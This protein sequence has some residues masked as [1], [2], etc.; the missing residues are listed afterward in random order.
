MVLR[1]DLEVCYL[2]ADCVE[3]CVG[4]HFDIIFKVVK[5]KHYGCHDMSH[6]HTQYHVGGCLYRSVYDGNNVSWQNFC[7]MNEK[8][9]MCIRMTSYVLFGLFPHEVHKEITDNCFRLV[10]RFRHVRIVIFLCGWLYEDDCVL[11]ILLK[12][13]I[14]HILRLIY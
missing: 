6:F 7:M 8:G 4:K 3:V 2:C 12:D 14:I 10:D 13:V 1:K 11:G 9:S 5:R